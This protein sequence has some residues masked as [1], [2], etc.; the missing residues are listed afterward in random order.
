MGSKLILPVA[1]QCCA[2][3]LNITDPDPQRAGLKDTPKRFAQA[4]KF[5]TSGYEEDPSEVFK[6]FED[7]AKGYH[8]MVF[9]RSIPFFSL[10]EH[11][12]TP[13][14]GFA[15]VGYIPN[16]KILGLSKFA[17]LVDIFAHRLQVQERMSAQIADAFFNGFERLYRPK[18]VGV[19]LQARHLCME[20]RGIQK[21]GTITTT[22]ALRGIFLNDPEIRVE[23]FNF[24]SH[25]KF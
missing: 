12:L 16:G 5:W 11:H 9:Q 13:F 15:H 2:D 4:W 20:S 1:E 18:G 8:D 25:V 21:L 7:G 6:N 14:F 23:F 19:V 22:S 17:R 10:C 24:V 3:L